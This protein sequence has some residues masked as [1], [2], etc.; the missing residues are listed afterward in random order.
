MSKSADSEGLE[1]SSIAPRGLAS[2]IGIPS[3]ATVQ[4]INRLEV[5]TPE[6][7]QKAMAN[8]KETGRI[9]I[10]YTPPE[11]GDPVTVSGKVLWRAL[12]IGKGELRPIFLRDPIAEA[13]DSPADDR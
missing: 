6:D 1:L 11:G 9:T 7:L 12:P 3:G 13:I 2:Q 5:N 8:C 4:Q 10:T